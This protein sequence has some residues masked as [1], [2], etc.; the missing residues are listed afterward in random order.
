M[1][2]AVIGS[3]TITNAAA[4]AEMLEPY[5]ERVTQVISGGAAGV[6]TLA[7]HWAKQHGKPLTVIRPD[8]RR[9]K[10]RLAPIMRNREI[11]RRADAVFILWDG[12]S[13]GTASTKREAQRQGKPIHERHTTDLDQLLLL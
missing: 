8:Y 6:D 9:Y 12:Q 13:K 11:V 3:R 1:R 2:I 5:A 4:L 7:D 10:G